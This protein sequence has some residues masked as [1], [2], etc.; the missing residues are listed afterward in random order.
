MLDRLAHARIDDEQPQARLP[1]ED[2]DG[3]PA[4]GEGREHLPGDLLRVGA[5]AAPRIAVV[6]G[7]EDER[8]PQPPRRRRAP[9]GGDPAGERLQLAEAPARLRLSVELRLGGA[10]RLRIDRPDAAEQR[11]QSHVRSS[12]RP[13]TTRQA[14][15][16]R[17][18]TTAFTRP[19]RSR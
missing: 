6:S 5:H 18:A 15:S 3:G 11:V 13:A 9:D 4:A 16:A 19:S 10:P 2:V 1:C 12:V 17:P 8:R 14:R 7:C